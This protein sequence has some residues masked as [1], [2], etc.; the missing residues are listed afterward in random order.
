VNYECSQTHYSQI[1]DYVDTVKK[2]FQAK[3]NWAQ[4][5]NDHYGSLL[6]DFT[7]YKQKVNQGIQDSFQN[8]NTKL[9]DFQSELSN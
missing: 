5:A 8:Q 3:V 2:D 1:Q 7:N 9:T 4:E 6:S